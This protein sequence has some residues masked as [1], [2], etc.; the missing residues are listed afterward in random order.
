MRTNAS[1]GRRPSRRFGAAAL[2][3][4]GLGS[5]AACTG[6]SG[7]IV[8]ETPSPTATASAT[9][10]A[11]PSASPTPLTDAE[12]LALMPPEAAYPDVRGAIATA[13]YFLEQY[14]PV[15]ETGDLTVWNALSMSDCIFCE[16]VREHVG[17]NSFAGDFETGGALMLNSETVVA[18]YYSVDGFTYVTFDY[19]EGPS[20]L[21]HSDETTEKLDDGEVGSISLRMTFSGSAWR[22]ADAEAEAH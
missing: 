11:S 6:G 21:H 20:I 2:V 14:A 19:S 5:L 3:A 18:N 10:S 13:Q 15:L 1:F 17:R 22:V 12:L 8:T 4:V 16:S 9:P 7:P